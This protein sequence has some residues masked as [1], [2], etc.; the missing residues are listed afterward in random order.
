[1]DKDKS[2]PINEPSDTTIGEENK[3]IDEDEKSLSFFEKLRRKSVEVAGNVKRRASL[4]SDTTK[5]NLKEDQE[6]G[7]QLRIDK[8][9]NVV[10]SEVVSNP[11]TE[12]QKGSYQNPLERCLTS[13]E[14]RIRRRSIIPENDAGGQS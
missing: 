13:R 9:E 7:K 14:T 10:A 8:L 11:S 4:M 3:E 6:D 1:M 2:G 12:T 5:D